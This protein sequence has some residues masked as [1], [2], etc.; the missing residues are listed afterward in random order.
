VVLGLNIA[1]GVLRYGAA[2]TPDDAAADGVLAIEVNRAPSRLEM[3]AS[4]QGAKQL[5]A[6]K[7]RFVQD[8]RT[9]TPSRVA[10][11]ATR[12]HSGWAYKQAFAR[13]S[14][15]CAAMLGCEDSGIPFIELKTKFGVL[16]TRAYNAVR[17]DGQLNC[18]RRAARSMQRNEFLALS[19]GA[20]LAA[21]ATGA[22][23]EAF[24]AVWVPVVV[25]VASALIILQ[26]R[27]RWQDCRRRVKADPL[28]SLGFRVDEGFT[29]TRR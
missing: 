26:Q 28:P 29:F 4:L 12:S 16:T 22:T 15:L 7:Q 14:V 1:G 24:A 10:L 18:Y 8:L 2:S 17:L 5:A 23:T 13:I 27:A 25:L 20:T 11:A 9:V 6:F 21:G 19:A 3:S